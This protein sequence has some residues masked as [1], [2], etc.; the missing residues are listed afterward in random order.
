[1]PNTRGWGGYASRRFGRPNLDLVRKVFL[2]FRHPHGPGHFIRLRKPL[3]RVA[4][5]YRILDQQIG[6]DFHPAA[7]SFLQKPPLVRAK[8]PEPV[9]TVSKRH[10]NI[11]TIMRG[12]QTQK[13][14][15]RSI[16][17]A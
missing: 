8:A 1:M 14:R 9:F 11:H 7:T 6:K 17:T 12:R 15:H 5:L 16:M 2:H 13:L 4:R 10:F 3:G